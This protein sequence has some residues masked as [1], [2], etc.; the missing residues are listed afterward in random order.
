MGGFR[1]PMEILHE[2]PRKSLIASP[3]PHQLKRNPNI[4]KSGGLALPFIMISKPKSFLQLLNRAS[5][6]AVGPFWRLF[7]CVLFFSR[8]SRLW[9]VISAVFDENLICKRLILITNIVFLPCEWGFA[10]KQLLLRKKFEKTQA[11]LRRSVKSSLGQIRSNSR[12]RG[13]RSRFKGVFYL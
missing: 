9:L 5:K 7:Q 11:K 2:K 13:F 8:R 6:L 12:F 4:L 10:W 1:I 3:H